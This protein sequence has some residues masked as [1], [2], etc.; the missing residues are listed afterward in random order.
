MQEIKPTTAL[1]KIAGLK[2]RIWA[3]QGGQGAGKTISILLL[4]INHARSTPDKLIII[5]S[6]ELTKMRLTVIK[7]FEDIMKSLGFFERSRFL[8]GTIY[9]FESGTQI[10]FV[11]LDKEDLGKG[12]RSDVVFVNEANKVSFEAYRELTS[13]AKRIIVDF[14]PNEEFWVHDEVIPRDD[15]QF[16]KLTFLDNEFLSSEERN[17][18]L[19]YKRKAY[20]DPDL[21][22][23]ERPDNIKSE[24]WRNKWH[25]YGLGIVGT[26][27]NRIFYWNEIPDEQFESI[28]SKSYYGVD[29]GAVDPWGIIE[30]K[31]HDGNLYLTELNYDSENKIL[32][33]LKSNEIEDIRTKEE[34]LVSW[35]FTRLEIPKNAIIVCDDNRPMKVLAL[36]RAGWDYAITAVKGKGSID[37]GIDLLSQLNVFFT[38]S[39][40]NIRT[41]QK[42]YSRQVDR[43]GIV[44]AE[45]VDAWN[46][47]IDPT[48]Y[49]ATFMQLQ[50]I[51]KI[52]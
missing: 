11:G 17:E 41:E 34:G 29:W 52:N 51:I 28:Q 31:Y 25:V 38:A 14:N 8:N 9:K 21:K 22:E 26:R 30:A 44:M 32:E 23:Y 13:R 37:D 20:K 39:S 19:M 5:A 45:A 7:D 46:H 35:M 24:Y 27:P 18:I 15:C 50:Q 40:K 16:L 49:I 48:R 42:N 33:S 36:R 12:L 2:K 1:R 43:H 47:T 6:E 4:L 10:K 3:I